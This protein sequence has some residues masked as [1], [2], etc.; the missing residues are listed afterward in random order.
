M[1]TGRRDV[2][3]LWHIPLTKGPGRRN[4]RQRKFKEKKKR[5]KPKK[6]SH[7]IAVVFSGEESLGG[8]CLK[9]E[10]L[11]RGLEILWYE[12][13]LG[14]IRFDLE[15]PLGCIAS[16]VD[17]LVLCVP[18]EELGHSPGSMFMLSWAAA[19]KTP[20]SAELA[21]TM[22]QGCPR[23]KGHSSIPSSVFVIQK[24]GA[25]TGMALTLLL[26]QHCNADAVL[27]FSTQSWD[28]PNDHPF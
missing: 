20:A 27:V 21:T 15:N 10:E 1:R 19:R 3:S 24:G 18:E 14:F 7:N 9:S 26:P 28:L 13:R 17:T 6:T 4:L 11:A 8:V 23:S 2:A 25:Q 12:A 22:A 5:K 16:S